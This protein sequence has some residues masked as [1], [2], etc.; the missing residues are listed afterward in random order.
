M[1]LLQKDPHEAC[2]FCLLKVVGFISAVGC[3]ETG[4]CFRVLIVVV[5]APV[6]T[7]VEVLI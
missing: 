5:E 4:V 2:L 7:A 3:S 1:E 6:L